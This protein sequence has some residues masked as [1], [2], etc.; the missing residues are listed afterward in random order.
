MFPDSKTTYKSFWTQTPRESWHKHGY[1]V[2]SRCWGWARGCPRCYLY[3]PG[4][5]T[6][7]NC[8]LAVNLLPIALANLSSWDEAKDPG[9]CSF[10]FIKLNI[11]LDS[12]LT[13]ELNSYHVPHFPIQS[14]LISRHSAL[15]ESHDDPRWAQHF[16]GRGG[17]GRG[18]W[19]SSHEYWGRGSNT[20][21]YYRGEQDLCVSTAETNCRAVTRSWSHQV[22]KWNPT[23]GF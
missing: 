1:M 19:R 23:L 9:R 6:W 13:H 7:W 5:S 15:T 2:L 10:T 8:L 21:Q 4:W 11:L 14:A 16:L 20:A 17:K 18:W 12:S 3:S 22:M